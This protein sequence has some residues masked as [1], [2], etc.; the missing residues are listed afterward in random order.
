MT[1]G[2]G[3]SVC[4][5]VQFVGSY[6]QAGGLGKQVQGGGCQQKTVRKLRRQQPLLP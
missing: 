3:L 5:S 4:K 1:L 6:L 2:P